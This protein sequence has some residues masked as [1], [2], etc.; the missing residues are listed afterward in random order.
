[1]TQVSPPRVPTTSVAPI[2]VAPVAPKP[3]STLQVATNGLRI[4]VAGT[5]GRLRVYGALAI[6][7][8]IIFGIFAFVGATTKADALSGARSDAA[9]LLRIQAIRINLVSADASLTNAFLVGGLEPPAERATYESSIANAAKALAEAAGASGADA[10]A[11]A[12]INDTITAYTGLVES[13]RAN[14]RQGYP[15]GAAYL[16]TATSLLR[17]DA[18]PGLE[19]IS[20]AEQDR[21]DDS[22]ASS[23]YASY[24]VIAGLVVPLAV[25]VLAQVWL[26]RRTRRVFNLP[27]VI[28]SALVVIIG[29]AVA[30]TMLWS[31]DKADRAR[32]GAY[33]DT[34][35]LGSARV[36]AFDAK[37]AE[38]L[39]LI[40]RGSGQEYQARYAA[41]A[42][43][44]KAILLDFE[45]RNRGD[46]SA[47]TA[48]LAYDATHVKIR[49]LDDGG[50]WQRAVDVATGTGPT[51]SNALFRKFDAASAI[52]L[53]SR[54]N[55]L[56]DQLD[57]AR[58]PL[59]ALAWIALL[60]GILAAIAAWR[61]ISNRLREYR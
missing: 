58:S 52:A 22:Y 16:R 37:S 8:C 43:D 55:Q 5:P 24:W 23:A 12:K 1:M 11:L 25:L 3:P 46:G 36:D 21:I 60:A 38:S 9:Q 59:I 53:D 17:N 54:S 2:P 57:S 26:T 31:Q 39:T 6:G 20:Q 40:A 7:A 34:L 14:N 13:A 41:L 18:L 56:R 27:L 45:N 4:L 44:T 49:G 28:A 35:E 29:A 61:G 30:G 10:A 42:A 50:D 33:F 47:R 48:F 19:A 51:D 32:S 15:I